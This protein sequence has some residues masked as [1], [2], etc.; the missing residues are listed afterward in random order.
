MRTMLEKIPSKIYL[1]T[2]RCQISNLRSN[3]QEEVIRLYTDEIT[4]KYLGG[5]LNFAEAKEKVE[6]LLNSNNK[7]YSIREKKNNRFLGL[8]YLNPY[9]DNNYIELSYELCSKYFGKGYAQ[10]AIQALLQ[11]LYILGIKE[12][13]AETQKKNTK[14]IKLLKKIGFIKMKELVRFNEEQIVFIKNLESK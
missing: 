3:D 11:H 1:N 2:P 9:Y 7:V 8:L 4:R 13:V 5:A 10:E 12:I 6:F 14:S